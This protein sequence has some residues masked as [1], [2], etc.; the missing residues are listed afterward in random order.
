M[1]LHC[2]RHSE[3]EAPERSPGQ[4]QPRAGRVHKNVEMPFLWQR[5]I[6]GYWIGELG[7]I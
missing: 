4:G 6:Q 3:E 7:Y 5:R 2:G 1:H